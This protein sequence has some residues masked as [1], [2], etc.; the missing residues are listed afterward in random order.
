M[1]FQVQCGLCHL[2][3]P[4]I[5]AEAVGSTARRSSAGRSACGRSGSLSHGASTVYLSRPTRNV[6]G[7]RRNGPISR[8]NVD[9]RR[10]LTYF[11]KTTHSASRQSTVY[12]AH[13]VVE[14]KAQNLANSL[15]FKS[16]SHTNI[17]AHVE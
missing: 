1:D 6:G 2:A 4:I 3:G 15:E 12:L 17:P 14:F 7:S 8:S 10:S 16:H 11:M 5:A 9:D 13:L